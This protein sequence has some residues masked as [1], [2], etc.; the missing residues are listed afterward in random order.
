M[1]LCRAH[2]AARNVKAGVGLGFPAVKEPTVCEHDSRIGKRLIKQCRK[3]YALWPADKETA[4][5]CGRPFV[6]TVFKDGVHSAVTQRDPK[7][8]K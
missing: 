4:Q 8:E 5:M 6:K 7:P 2:A 3:E 1:P